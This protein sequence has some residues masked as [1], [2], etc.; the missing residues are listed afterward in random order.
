MSDAIATRIDRMRYTKNTASSRL[1]L[2]AI[3]FDILFFISIYKSDVCTYYYTITIGA[4]II[5]NLVFL[6]AAFLCSE[7]V[8]NYRIG[9]SWALIVLGIVQ[10][11]RI[12]ILPMNAH[13]AIVNNMPV[14]GDGQF[15]RVVIYLAASAVCLFASA[16]VNMKKSRTLAKYTASLQA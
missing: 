15:I 8:K 7:G 5:Y 6:L 3:V 14:M 12:F 13:G 11:A 4:S 2:L 1:A 9:Y 10:I 16:L